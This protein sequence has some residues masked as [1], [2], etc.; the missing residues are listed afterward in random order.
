MKEFRNKKIG[1]T[2]LKEAEN[3]AKQKG[4]KEIFLDVESTNDLAI[5]LY[6]RLGYKE[7]RR[8][9]GYEDYIRMKKNII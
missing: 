2:L 3:V 7:I 6:E 8:P 4:F 5:K 1:L 9:I